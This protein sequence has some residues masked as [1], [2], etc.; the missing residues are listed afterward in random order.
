MESMVLNPFIKQCRELMLGEGWLLAKVKIKIWGYKPGPSE[1]QVFAMIFSKQEISV[2]ALF[3]SQL[4]VL[5][6]VG[7]GGFIYNSEVE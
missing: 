5:C 7:I 4:G 2:V 3:I 1:V 6:S